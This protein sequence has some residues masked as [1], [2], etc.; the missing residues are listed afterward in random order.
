[1]L[2]TGAYKIPIGSKQGTNFVIIIIINTVYFYTIEHQHI[3]TIYRNIALYKI[4][5]GVD[6]PAGQSQPA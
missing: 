6:G 2:V 3:Y 1:M 4:T 5:L